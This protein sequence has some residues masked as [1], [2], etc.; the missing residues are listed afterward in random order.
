MLP[1]LEIM[2]VL[3][4]DP[5]IAAIPAREN[6]DPLVDVTSFGL[7]Y[8]G[9]G[10]AG[11]YVR[12]ALALRLASAQAQLPGGIQ[13]LIREGHRSPE[14]Q[15]GIFSRYSQSLRREM[16]GL[17]EFSLRRLT[18]RFVSPIGV[19]PHVAGAAVDLT[20]ADASG[21]P[22]WMGTP[23]DATPERAATRARSTP[24]TS[25]RTRA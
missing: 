7:L 14:D 6:G 9:D 17:D 8:T 22:L 3:L 23:I 21:A 10:D 12:H 24:R 11:R 18:S 1:N 20:L 4:A 19:A 2:T 25:A 16:P 15:E 5:Q 13:L